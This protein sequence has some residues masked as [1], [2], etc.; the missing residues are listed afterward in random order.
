[1]TNFYVRNDI[2][3][4]RK[5]PDWNKTRLSLT[6]SSKMVLDWRVSVSGHASPSNSLVV[7]GPDCPVK[8][9][10]PGKFNCSLAKVLVNSLT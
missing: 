6:V 5:S 8:S 4:Y 2:H 9:F 7:S 3:K 10:I 1:M